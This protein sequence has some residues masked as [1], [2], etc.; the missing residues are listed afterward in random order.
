MAYGGSGADFVSSGFHEGEL[1]HEQQE[2]VADGD[3]NY[4]KRQDGVP[5]HRRL[6]A[7]TFI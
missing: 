6:T 5:G 3:Q 4:E 7:E 2:E 1:E